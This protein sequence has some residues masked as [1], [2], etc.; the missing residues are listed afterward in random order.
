MG[1]YYGEE[2][3]YIPEKEI[4]KIKSQ[5]IDAMIEE[6]LKDEI[7]PE[8]DR[9]AP[10]E[11]C[12]EYGGNFGGSKN[13]GNSQFEHYLVDGAILQC[14]KAKNCGKWNRTTLRVSKNAST[15]NGRKMATVLDLDFE[16]FNIVCPLEETGGEE[17]S[18]EELIRKAE[19][20]ENMIRNTRYMTYCYGE[21]GRY[22]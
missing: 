2:T 15:V 17:R 7:I 21:G 5:M 12:L 19:R 20:W 16:P 8:G 1:R 4:A 9:E 10:R 13:G 3:G 22:R 6:E 11:L 18:C 14:D